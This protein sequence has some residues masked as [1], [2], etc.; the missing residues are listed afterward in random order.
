M[1]P[2]IEIPSYGVRVAASAMRWRAVR[3]SGPGGQNVNK[4]ASKVEL[5][6]TLSDVEGLDAA[7]LSRLRRVAGRFLNDEDELVIT[8][9]RTRDQGRN[10]AD[11]H[12]KLQ[13]LLERIAAPP[14]PRRPTKPTAGSRARRLGA[15]R[16]QGQKKADR[17]QDG[18]DDE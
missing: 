10:L 11:A 14:R 1:L 9:V 8:S 13:A 7:A 4:V 15:K 12:G 17:R 5:R 16:R 3:A 2:A 6:V 18:R